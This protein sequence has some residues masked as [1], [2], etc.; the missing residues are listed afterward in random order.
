GYFGIV[1]QACAARGIQLDALGIGVGRSESHPERLLGQY[2]LV[3]AK[4]RAAL[5]ALAMGTSVIAC[6]SAGLAGMVTPENY[7]RL[8]RLNFGV[9]CLRDPIT[10]ENVTREL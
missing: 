3:F 1:R 9:R 5:E 7:E 6:D 10:F 8:R 4:A 2:D